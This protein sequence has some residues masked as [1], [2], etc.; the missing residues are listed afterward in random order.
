MIIAVTD[1]LLMAF[2]DGELDPRIASPT[3]EAIAN[4]EDVRRRFAIYRE[5]REK[6]A[7]AF[8]AIAAEPVPDRLLR[9]FAGA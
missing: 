2:A 5:T 6:L 7:A 1:E 9:I 4:N 3:A 8:G